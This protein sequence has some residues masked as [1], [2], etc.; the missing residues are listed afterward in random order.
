MGLQRSVYLTFLLVHGD[1]K[2]HP[3]QAKSQRLKCRQKA[4]KNC[5]RH[6]TSNLAPTNKHVA[7]YLF[8][9]PSA[10]CCFVMRLQSL[11]VLWFLHFERKLYFGRPASSSVDYEDCYTETI[12]LWFQMISGLY[13]D[14]GYLIS[15]YNRFN[16]VHADAADLVHPL[17]GFKVQLWDS[18]PWCRD[19]LDMLNIDDHWPSMSQWV[20]LKHIKTYWNTLN[21]SFEVIALNVGIVTHKQL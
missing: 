8:A 2:M 16:L 15:G 6:P 9:W 19:A 1:T 3:P 4:S 17:P 7:S 10:F 18:L 14:T 5:E 21:Q 12:L 20:S 11:T 13:L